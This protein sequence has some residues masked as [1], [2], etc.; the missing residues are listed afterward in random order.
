MAGN[1]DWLVHS[2]NL[3]IFLSYCTCDRMLGAGRPGRLNADDILLEITEK[4]NLMSNTE[5]N[6]AIKK[7]SRGCNWPVGKWKIMYSIQS[8]ARMDTKSSSIWRIRVTQTNQPAVLRATHTSS[9][10]KHYIVHP[11]IYPCRYMKSVLYL[12]VCMTSELL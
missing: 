1:Y 2:A 4:N 5:R 3:H 9:L 6:L 11:G 12:N 7:K 10:E 8:T